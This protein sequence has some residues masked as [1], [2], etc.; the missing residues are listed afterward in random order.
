MPVEEDQLSIG[1][2]TGSKEERKIFSRKSI[3]FVCDTCG[4]ISQIVKDH[5][6]KLTS[7]NKSINKDQSIF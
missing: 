6:P 2:L 7:D 4:P 1:A 5:I 3:D